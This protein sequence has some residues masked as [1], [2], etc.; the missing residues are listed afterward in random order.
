MNEHRGYG[1]VRFAW[2]SL[3]VQVVIDVWLVLAKCRELPCHLH[4]DWFVGA[5]C[6]KSR[7]ARAV[8]AQNLEIM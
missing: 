7:A 5:V 1:G 4:C 8:T 2:Q 3:I 6:R